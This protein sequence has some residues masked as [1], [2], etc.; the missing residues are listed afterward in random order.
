MRDSKHTPPKRRP[1]PDAEALRRDKYAAGGET[2]QD[3]AHGPGGGPQQDGAH[4]RGGETRQGGAH[5]RGGEVRRSDAH[6]PGG[7][8][9]R[10]GAR[11]PSGEPRQGSAHGPGGGPRQGSA[12][13]PGGGPRQGSAHGPG[14]GPRQDGA[15]GPGG[16]PRRDGARNPSGEPRQDGAHGPGGGPRQDGAHGRGGEVRQ[17]SAHDRS[18]GP[19]RDGAPP[20]PARV[21]RTPSAGAVWLLPESFRDREPCPNRKKCGGCQLQNMDYARQLAFKQGRVEKLIGPFCPV[22]PIIG[23]D[24][25]YNY[26]NKVQAAFGTDRNGRIISGVY[27]SSSHRIVPVD[28]CMLEDAAADRIIVTIRSMLPRYKLTAYDERTGRGFLRHVLVKRAF[29]TGQVMVV[30]VAAT[31]MF[32]SRSAFVAELVERHPEIS[33]V[34]LNVND[35]F[36]SLVLGQSERVLFGSGYIEDVLCSCRFRISAKSFYQINPVQTEKL[37]STAVEYAALTGSE[38]VLDAYCG[39]GTIGMVASRSAGHVSGVELNR[40]A[41]KDAI[42]NARLNS[43]DN[44]YFTC[45]DAGQFMED[46]ALAGERADLVFLDPPRAGSTP[47]FIDSL[48]KMAPQRAVY[49]SCSCDTLSRDLELFRQRGYRAVKAQPVDM[50]PHTEHIECVVLLEKRGPSFF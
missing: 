8:P 42:F 9:R 21:S 40:D 30:L 46:M 48:A 43:I 12:H 44:C 47:R 17:G 6:I 18:G 49:I 33:T 22:K 10:D 32:P 26:R 3:G 25:P 41:V 11:N 39:I 14:G 1:R 15:H 31:H 37:Y 38:T 45:A 27:Q 50:F 16:G 36:T 35:K 5:D 20:S 24:S 34:I 7:G 4:G 28:E 19:R 13:I 23:M 29:A 2:R